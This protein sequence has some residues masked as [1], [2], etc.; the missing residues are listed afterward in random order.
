MAGLGPYRSLRLAGR[1]AATPQTTDIQ[2][3][4]GVSGDS[5]LETGR[6]GADASGPCGKFGDGSYGAQPEVPE[7]GGQAPESPN[8]FPTYAT[9][10]WRFWRSDLVPNFPHGPL[11]TDK[12]ENTAPSRIPKYEEQ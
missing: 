4:Y 11:G 6:D 9:Q 1:E 10:R 2:K 7:Q 5:V 12:A 8:L 3:T